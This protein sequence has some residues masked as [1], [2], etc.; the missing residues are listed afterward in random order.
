ME[1]I[2]NSNEQPMVEEILKLHPEEY[3][4]IR[5]TSTMLQKSIIDASGFIRS[6][7]KGGNIIDYSVHPQGGENKIVKTS[8]L[9]ENKSYKL[10]TSFYRP[11][12]KKGDPRFWILGLKQLHLVQA[13]DTPYHLVD[14]ASLES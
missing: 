8:I 13:N 3:C 1:F 12:T 7:F 6:L 2:L 4:L 11:H 5:L 14:I 9:L 10:E